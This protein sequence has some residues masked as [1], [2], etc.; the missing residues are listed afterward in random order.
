MIIQFR[1]KEHFSEKEPNLNF[2]H[3]RFGED[4][5]FRL[6]N[7]DNYIADGYGLMIRK[8]TVTSKRDVPTGYTDEWFNYEQRFG[9]KAMVT[10]VSSDWDGNPETESD[11]IEKAACWLVIDNP[12]DIDE[13]VLKIN[14]DIH[15]WNP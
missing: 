6:F 11:H 12:H 10:F 15:L 9:F 13:S 4:R 5:W 2:G 14:R 7:S 3:Y 1:N 8:I